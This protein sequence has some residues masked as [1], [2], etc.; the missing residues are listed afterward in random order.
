MEV[1]Q[2]LDA[3]ESSADDIRE[4]LEKTEKG[5]VRQ[6][7]NNCV[8]VLR[9]DPVLKGV[10]RKN[11]LTER[12]DIIKPL[13]WKRSV[14]T[15]ITD[16]D[17]FQI[18]LYLENEY[19]LMKDRL[20][21]KAISIVAN[22]NSYHPI[23]DYLESLTW[24]GKSRIDKVL[25]RYLGVDNN[26]YTWE[27]MGLFMEAAIERIYNPGCKFELMMC[28]VGGQGAGKSTFFR[29]LA[30]KDEWFSDD[31]RRIDDDQVYRKLVGHW[32]IEMSEMIATVNARSI[33]DIKS[34]ISRQK[35]TYK[36][37]YETHPADRPRQ[38]VFGGTSNNLD[39]LPLDRTGNRRFAP[40]LVHPERVEKHILEDEKEA[41]EYFRQM[42]AEALVRYKKSKTHELKLSP[43][44]EGYLKEMQKQFMPE[45]TKLGIIQAWLEECNEEYVCSTMIYKE[46]LGHEASE[47]KNWETREINSIMNDAISGWEAVTS[48]RFRDYGIQRGW[49]RVSKDDGFVP[50]REEEIPFG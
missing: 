34:F 31:L 39:F 49:K 18:E 32:I 20:I 26:Y 16:T 2:I 15:A 28:L 40:V 30:G 50:A 29:F 4:D 38:C 5:G 41:R 3:E 27:I 9:R 12:M 19:G 43:M 11:E 47:P 13:G 33:E 22:E 8:T 37:P 21:N 14:G 7:L 44:A 1:G 46:A 45:D 42:W 6:T 17:I 25:T 24:D 48:H 23:R 36:I 35:E 10:I